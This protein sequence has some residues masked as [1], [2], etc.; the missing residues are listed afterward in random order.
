MVDH[1]LW[2]TRVVGG[3]N[4]RRVKSDR[5][6]GAS[7]GRYVDDISDVALVVAITRGDR[8]GLAEI[9]R[10]HGPECY[11]LAQ[12][13]CGHDRAK[14]VVQQVFLEVWEKPPRYNPDRG[15]LR[16]FLLTQVYGRSIDRF[17]S[18]GARH[19]ADDKVWLLLNA[20]PE[21]QRDAIVL[22]HFEG[23]TYRDVAD[24][25]GEPEG[26][27]KSGIRAGLAGLRLA[28]SDESDQMAGL[29]KVTGGQ[30]VGSSNFLGP[31][32]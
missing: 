31:T 25:L 10:R 23:C 16:T 4:S 9:Y 30:E 24:L 8:D 18:D 22:A 21:G 17:R 12:R 13:V 2:R 27:I 3:E 19:S 7:D 28:L 11:G 20:L 15:S 32:R 26:T 6:G 5:K 14:E 1:A 29:T